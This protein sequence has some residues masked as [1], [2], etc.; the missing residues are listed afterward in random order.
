LFRLTIA[1]RHEEKGRQI[2][3]KP[4]INENEIQSTTESTSR[5]TRE[6]NA[7]TLGNSAGMPFGATHVRKN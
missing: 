5:V 2:R 3:S 6:N 4:I 7:Q 1:R